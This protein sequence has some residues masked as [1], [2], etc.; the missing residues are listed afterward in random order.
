MFRSQPVQAASNAVESAENRLLCTPL[1]G[2][3]DMLANF[4]L[5]AR[6]LRLFLASA[7][8]CARIA[9][10]RVRPAQRKAGQRSSLIRAN[11][12]SR[13]IT[14]TSRWGAVADDDAPQDEGMVPARGVEPLT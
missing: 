8:I 1:S 9:F 2:H 5:A 10:K 3:L 7:I 4:L 6:Q 13:E 11:S 12:D 14:G